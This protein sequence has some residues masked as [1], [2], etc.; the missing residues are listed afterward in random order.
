MNYQ[1]VETGYWRISG[2][3]VAM[4]HASATACAMSSRSNGSR[5]WEGSLL[6][7]SYTSACLITISQTE[8]G[9]SYT[10]LEGSTMAPNVS[11]DRPRSSSTNHR[12]VHVSGRILMN[13]P[14]M[15]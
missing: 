9:L 2:S 3:G 10:S 11:L 13:S 1:I 14:R 15:R 7:W 5:W 4:V 8:I 6:N 12:N